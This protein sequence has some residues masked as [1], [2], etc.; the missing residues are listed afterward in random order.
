MLLAITARYTFYRRIHRVI[1]NRLPFVRSAEKSAT[2]DVFSLRDGWS[3]TSN[4]Y[5]CIR[6]YILDTYVVSTAG[7]LSLLQIT[8]PER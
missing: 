6:T 1:F 5:C 7:N 2:I 8:K 3:F 4:P